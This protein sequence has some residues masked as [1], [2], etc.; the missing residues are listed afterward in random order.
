MY[1]SCFE[2]ARNEGIFSGA[3]TSEQIFPQPSSTGHVIGATWGELRI[4]SQRNNC[5]ISQQKHDSRHKI[6][7]SRLKYTIVTVEN[8]ISSQFKQNNSL[9]RP[10]VSFSNFKNKINQVYLINMVA[11]RTRQSR[12][13][14][15]APRASNQQ[16]GGLSNAGLAPVAA[17]QNKTKSQLFSEVLAKYLPVAPEGLSDDHFDVTSVAGQKL[18]KAASHCVQDCWDILEDN[19]PKMSCNILMRPKLST[20]TEVRVL[21]SEAY[22]SPNTNDPEN[23][24]DVED[25]TQDI[26]NEAD[27]VK[28]EK[29]VIAYFM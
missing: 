26:L 5:G 8:K 20:L 3:G 7:H 9:S 24:T 14:S 12:S 25:L 29:A 22:W 2:M 11:T 28:N 1:A 16:G 18:F 19:F 17:N 27:A 21:A 6:Y 15:P 23:V 10:N 13:L 4:F